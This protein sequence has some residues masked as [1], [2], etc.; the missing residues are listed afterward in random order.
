MTNA[1]E[2][3]VIFSLDIPQPFSLENTQFSLYPKDSKNHKSEIIAVTFDPSLKYDKKS[4]I[5]KK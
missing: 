3:N 1:C 4:G 2:Q 5:Q